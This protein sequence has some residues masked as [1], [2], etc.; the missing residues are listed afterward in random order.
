MNKL[1]PIIIIEDDLDDQEILIAVFKELDYR[2]EII[3]FINGDQVLDY[4]NESKVKPFLIL[5]DIN[6]PKLNGL[7]LRDKVHN[8]EQ[9]KL[10]CIPY[11]F[12]TS[13]KS[14]Q[15]VIEAYSKSIQGFF[16]KPSNFEEIK[17]VINNI[18]I[19]WQ[20]CEAPKFPQDN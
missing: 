10:K 6:L 13:S 7:Q 16:V 15:A 3:Y 18:F 12:F 17:R 2:N 4:L 1:G 8:N 14:Q 20:D 19:Y 9:L 5:S 11:L